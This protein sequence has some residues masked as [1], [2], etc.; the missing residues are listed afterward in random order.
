MVDH[1]IAQQHGGKSTAD[2]L[3]LACS[4]CNLHKGPNVAGIDPLTKQ[5]VRL[6]HPRTDTWGEHFRWEGAS[7]AG[8]TKVGR[9]TIVVLAM[10]HPYR[11]AARE[12]LLAAGKIRLS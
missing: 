9:A 12:A 1:V 5:L 7:L 6:F 3:A 2:N 11:L 4:R 10:N 8:L